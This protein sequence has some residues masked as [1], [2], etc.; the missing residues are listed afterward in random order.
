[1]ALDLI[2]FRMSIV[3]F[4]NELTHNNVKYK[5]AH[6][7]NEFNRRNIDLD[8]FKLDMIEG[9]LSFNTPSNYFHEFVQKTVLGSALD[10][11]MKAANYDVYV[12]F[13]FKGK[14]GTLLFE[15]P[16]LLAANNYGPEEGYQILLQATDSEIK[17]REGWL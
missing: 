10:D 1:M 16:L 9:K 12:H 11:C 3:S 4:K 8:Y 17:I 5:E 15:K 14:K 7:K 6:I 2:P 13:E